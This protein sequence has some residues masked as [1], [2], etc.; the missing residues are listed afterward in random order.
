[1]SKQKLRPSPYQLQML[2]MLDREAGPV[3]EQVLNGCVAKALLARRW[4][5]HDETGVKISELGRDAL[6]RWL[7]VESI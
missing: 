2:D 5:Q 3:Q 1:M 7:L 6:R 4:A